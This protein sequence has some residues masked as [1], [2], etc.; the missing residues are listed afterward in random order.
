MKKFIVRNLCKNYHNL[1]VVNNFSFEFES[2]LYLLTGE[3]GKGKSTL[4]KMFSKVIKPSN[5]YY[6]ID[7]IDRCFMCERIEPGS[8]NVLDYLKRIS[9]YNYV[10]TNILA[11]INKWDIPNKD[12][13]SLSKGNRQKVAILMT[14]LCEADLYL[15]D[16]P[17]D[18][19]D[20]KAI[21]LFNEY[22]E[23]LI[24]LDKIIIISTHEK[25][26][27]SKMKYQEV[28]I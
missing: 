22:I 1:V 15:F 28:K 7:E 16:E 8:G 21:K 25:K 17:T 20:K 9:Q 12:I 13:S 5:I 27:F 2:G 4:L 19:L 10:K 6:H 23:E 14:Y 3:N 11:L 24:N 18:A 26:Y